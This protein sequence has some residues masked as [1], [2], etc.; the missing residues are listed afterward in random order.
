MSSQ[1]VIPSTSPSRDISKPWRE[2]TSTSTSGPPSTIAKSGGRVA[3]NKLTVLSTYAKG[4]HT[5]AHCKCECGKTHDTRLANV[6][7]GHTTSCGCARRLAQA[8]SQDRPPEK[9]TT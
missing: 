7:S 9:P 2:S 3:E 1:Q 8:T 6:K 5:Y 4:R